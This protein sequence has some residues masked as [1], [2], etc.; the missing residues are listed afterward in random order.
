MRQDAKSLYQAIGV[1]PTATTEE[2][3]EACLELGAKYHPENGG[4]SE[5]ARRRYAEIGFA[6]EILTNPDKRSLYDRSQDLGNLHA[7][8]RYREPAV[9]D[10][11][12]VIVSVAFCAI[13]VLVSA[14]MISYYRGENFDVIVVGAILASTAFLI[15]ST[16][17]ALVFWAL[18]FLF[19][20]KR[21]REA[22]QISL[23]AASVL[24]GFIFALLGTY[25]SYQVLR[26]GP[27]W[28][29]LLLLPYGLLCAGFKALT[30]ELTSH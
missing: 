3:R 20:G 21:E 18:A 30:K 28:I 27:H 13:S 12:A 16:L 14:G 29:V 22:G 11:V 17:L 23:I 9:S 6:Y 4:T 7:Q 25:E 5:D 8:S 2:I 24:L 19:F 1:A 15:A 10:I 26:N